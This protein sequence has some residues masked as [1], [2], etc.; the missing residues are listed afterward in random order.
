MAITFTLYLNQRRLERYTMVCTVDELC[1]K[2]IERG[3]A[4]YE[5]TA[6]DGHAGVT[7]TQAR[8]RHLMRTRSLA[9]YRAELLSA[10]V[11]KLYL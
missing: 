9:A 8:L 2:M 5:C 3:M 6:E 4:G 1:D 10:L 7:L 11:E